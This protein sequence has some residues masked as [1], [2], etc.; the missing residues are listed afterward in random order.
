M[1][2]L[3]LNKPDG[4]E[5]TDARISQT[6]I[7]IL[8]NDD[9]KTNLITIDFNRLLRGISFDS[10]QA[11]NLGELLISKANLVEQRGQLNWD[12]ALKHLREARRQ[13]TE[14]VGVPGANPHYALQNVF[15]PLFHR[16]Y[17]GER[18]AELYREMMNVS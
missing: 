11:R 17:K 15:Q 14:L 4:D 6:E 7:N 10:I 13:Y 2:E 8:V 3:G 1:I 5:K 9:E 18:S 16:Y 12:L